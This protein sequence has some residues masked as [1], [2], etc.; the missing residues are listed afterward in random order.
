VGDFMES[1]VSGEEIPEEHDRVVSYYTCPECGSD[2]EFRQGKRYE[3]E[4][5]ETKDKH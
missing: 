4:E 3:E 2:Y 5:I 1:E